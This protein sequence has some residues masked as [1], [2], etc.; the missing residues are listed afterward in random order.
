[1]KRKGLKLMPRSEVIILHETDFDKIAKITNC[2]YND[3]I[4]E[5][6]E[7]SKQN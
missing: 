4:K 7:K 2:H 5:R 3:S 6:F 1:M